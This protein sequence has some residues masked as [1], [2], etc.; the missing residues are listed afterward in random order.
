M[1]KSTPDKTMVENMNTYENMTWAPDLSS[2]EKLMM[3]LSSAKNKIMQAVSIISTRDTYFKLH[4]DAGVE[5][6]QKTDNTKP[7]K[8]V[9]VV[10]ETMYIV[11]KTGI[12]I[13]EVMPVLLD[14]VKGHRKD[15]FFQANYSNWIRL[16][17]L[18]T[19]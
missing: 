6:L 13:E 12:P 17:D 15:E 14:D 7:K 2:W 5:P 3:D 8:K 4:H 19:E 16:L 9:D 1:L 11:E 18:T 10:A